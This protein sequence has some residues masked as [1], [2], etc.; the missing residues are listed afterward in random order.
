MEYGTVTWYSESRGEGS[1]IC[2]D[3]SGRQIRVTHSSI[4][5]EGFKILHE[6]Q[7]VTFEIVGTAHGPAAASVK[8]CDD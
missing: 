8:P 7:R 4:E 2:D 6:G 3:G 5:C 1:I